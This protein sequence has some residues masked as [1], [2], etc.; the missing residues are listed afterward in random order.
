MNCPHCGKGI[1]DGGT[2]CPFCEKP[3]PPK[4]EAEVPVVAADKPEIKEK[5]EEKTEEKNKEITIAKTEEKC[6]EKPEKEPEKEPE[7]KAKKRPKKLFWIILA[8]ILALAVAAAAL[9]VF[10]R[11]KKENENVRAMFG[12]LHATLFN[13]R[14]LTLTSEGFTCKAAWGDDLYTSDLSVET[15]QDGVPVRV[16]L[17][18]GALLLVSETGGNPQFGA[19]LKQVFSPDKETERGR[20][21]AVWAGAL[22][23]ALA[24]KSGGALPD[25][26]AQA[27][28][29][30]VNALGALLNEAGDPVAYGF[31]ADGVLPKRVQDLLL[32]TADGADEAVLNVTAEES[33]GAT[34]F[35]AEIDVQAFLKALSDAMARDKKLPDAWR[36]SADAFGALMTALAELPEARER[37]EKESLTICV[38]AKNGLATEISF[39]ELTLTVTDVNRTEPALGNFDTYY[40]ALQSNGMLI[41]APALPPTGK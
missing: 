27:A 9:W 30:W 37:T 38:V 40:T 3:L 15:A 17:H 34:V 19:D 2:L 16:M 11:P 10:S 22:K 13:T 4:A 18:G 1:G 24:K 29:R 12:A 36:E 32:E 20:L 28:E 7:K 14:S 26:A 8:V 39:G 33:E 35:T 31:L 5:S 21:F 6:E 25:E 41:T 23:T